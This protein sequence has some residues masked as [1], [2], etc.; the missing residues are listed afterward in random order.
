LIGSLR[1]AGFFVLLIA[2]WEII[3]RVGVWD[4]A[5]FP[6]P[7][8][9]ARSLQRSFADG[10]LLISTSVSI[11]RMLI[12]FAVSLVIGIPLGLVLARVRWLDETLGSLVLGLQTL[13]S[14]C[15]LPLA[16]LW[17]GLNDG[18]IIFVVVIGALLAITVSVRDGVKN[19][20]PV[21]LRAART[22]GASPLAIY[23]EV[24]LPA[25]LPSMITGAKLGWSFAWRSLMAGELL[26]V[27][28]GLGHQMMMGRELADMSQVIAVMI[29]IVGLGLITDYL[30]FGSLEQ[31]VRERWGLN[32]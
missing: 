3:Y 7:W 16:L 19:V 6:S 9:V 22:M 26:F 18:A 31:R 28:V 20:P 13:P 23:T 30:I 10:S 24:L 12:G 1:R 8:Q 14:I 17:F 27:S 4:P 15:W 29:V 21:Y 11:R 32:A 5:L 2:L 25:S